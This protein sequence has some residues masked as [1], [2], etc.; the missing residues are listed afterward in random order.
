MVQIQQ[1]LNRHNQLLDADELS[2]LEEVLID[3]AAQM[4]GA[5]RLDVA[6]SLAPE[7]ELQAA[8]TFIGEMDTVRRDAM[9]RG[10]A[11]LNSIPD[12]EWEELTNAES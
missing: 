9:R 11:N 6:L 8:A 10:A 5:T 4:N 7:D 1:I 2:A 3:R 12:D